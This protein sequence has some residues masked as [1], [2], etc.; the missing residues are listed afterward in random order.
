MSNKAIMWI[1]I[2]GLALASCG[3]TAQERAWEKKQ[4][5]DS[6]AYVTV[7]KINKESAKEVKLKI[8]RE[9]YEKTKYDYDVAR[10]K[11]RTVAEFHLARTP[12]K[13]E[14]QIQ[15][16]TQYIDKLNDSLATL[17]RSIAYLE[18]RVRK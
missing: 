6:I 12:E 16:Q 10:D 4:Q 17:S 9:K 2:G 18:K 8:L 14:K 3:K 13:K 15:K 1:T 7:A 11:L 5:N